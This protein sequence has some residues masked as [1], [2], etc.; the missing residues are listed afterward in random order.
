MEVGR[1]QVGWLLCHDE[2]L[3]SGRWKAS[4]HRT[5]SHCTA[6]AAAACFPWPLAPRLNWSIMISFS[7]FLFTIHIIIVVTLQI[8]LI[9]PCAP[10]S[11]YMYAFLRISLCRCYFVGSFMALDLVQILKKISLVLHSLELFKE[12]LHENQIETFLVAYLLSTA[13]LMFVIYGGT[14]N[15]VSLSNI[16]PLYMASSRLRSPAN[17]S[18]NL[19]FTRKVCETFCLCITALKSSLSKLIAV[20]DFLSHNRTICSNSLQ[21]TTKHNYKCLDIA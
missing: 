6:A 10:S 7:I 14:N 11:F 15:T 4:P 17:Y 16:T 13:V 12:I 1:K 18:L 8:R 5:L 3:L 9:L 2:N 20:F 19:Y 21:K